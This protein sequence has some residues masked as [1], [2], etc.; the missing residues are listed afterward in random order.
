MLHTANQRWGS[1]T[2]LCGSG[3]P[4][5]YLWLMDPDPAPF[6]RDFKDVKNNFF[7]FIFFLITYPQAYYLQSW[8]LNF[9]LKFWV[10]ILFFKQFFSQLNTLMRRRQDSEPDPDLDPCLWRMDPDPGGPKNASGSPTLLPT[11]NLNVNRSKKK[12]PKSSHPRAD[13]K[14]LPEVEISRSA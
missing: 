9:L 10:K 12:N 4:D 2:F 8:K 11:Q 14:F 13:L 3:S 6:F 5:P 7:S 1:V